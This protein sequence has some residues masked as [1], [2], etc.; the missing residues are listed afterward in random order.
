MLELRPMVRTTGNGIRRLL[1]GLCR[2]NSGEL[3]SLNMVYNL[4]L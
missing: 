4:V 3:G 1:W 2:L